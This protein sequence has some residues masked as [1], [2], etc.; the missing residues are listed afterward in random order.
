MS[1]IQKNTFHILRHGVVPNEV[2]EAC[3]SNP[4]VI[5]TRENCY[6]VL[7]RSDT[8]RYLSIVL[9]SKGK[10]MVRVITAR[11]MDYKERK[12]FERKKR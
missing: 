12:L 8:G 5:K 6:L 7:G 10:G 11:D 3:Y 4:L 9:T 1:G 2:E